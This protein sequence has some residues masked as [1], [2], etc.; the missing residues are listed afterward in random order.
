MNNYIEKK[1]DPKIS[2]IT[3]CFNAEKSVAQTIQSVLTQ[4]YPFVEYIVIDGQSTDNTIAQILPYRNQ[5]AHFISEPDTG[6]YDAMNK[7]LRMATGDIIGFLNADD[8]YPHAQVLKQVADAFQSA[9]CD[10]LWGDLLYYQPISGKIVRYWKSTPY[11]L[12]A[13]GR[14]WSPPHP[15]FFAKKSLYDQWGGFDLQ[16]Q[17]GNDIEL[18]MR[19]VEKHHSKTYYLPEVLVHMQIGGI[20]NRSWR[21]MLIQNQEIIRACHHLKLPVNPLAFWTYKIIKL[22]KQTLAKPHASKSA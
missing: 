10:C 14:G 13:F 12:G 20:S 1:R 22:F 7:G 9:L 21:N 5:L 15:T 3:V 6:M 17:L 16:Y 11:Q 4:N 18:M 8:C 2:I 19:F